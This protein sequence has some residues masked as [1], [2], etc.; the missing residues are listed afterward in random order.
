M[1]KDSVVSI[2]KNAKDYVSGE[3]ISKEL[4]ISRA[5]INKAVKSLRSEGYTIDSVTN[6][7]YILVEGPDHLTA[8]EMQSYLGEKRMK[9]VVCL[10]TTPS[11]NLYLHGIAYEAADRTVAVANEQTAGRGRLGRTFESPK[12][13]GIYLSYLMK[14]KVAPQDATTITAW[15]AVAVCRAIERACDVSPEIKWVNDIILDHKK[16]SGILTEMSLESETGR[17]Q[18]IIIGIGINVNEG[19]GD[20]PKELRDKATSLRIATGQGFSRA[21]LAAALIEELDAMYDAWPTESGRYLE[22]YQ[23]RCKMTA[24]EVSVIPVAPATPEEVGKDAAHTPRHAVVLG[25]NQD[26]SIQVKYEDGTMEAL[27]SGEVSIRGMYG[28]L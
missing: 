12:D 10:E 7:G 6:K 16:V 24:K 20:F 22:E 11:T 5:A 3:V 1:T 13:T 4:G 23:K 15:T 27:N 8:G 26:F 21:K 9:Q 28:Y 18:S 2:L 17:I 19:E 25:I 14:P